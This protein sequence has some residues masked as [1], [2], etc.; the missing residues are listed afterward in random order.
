MSYIQK[1]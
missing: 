1:Q